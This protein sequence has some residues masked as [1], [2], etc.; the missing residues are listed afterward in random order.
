LHNSLPTWTKKA[1]LNIIEKIGSVQ[2]LGLRIEADYLRKSLKGDE[3]ARGAL[4][5]KLPQMMRPDCFG[6]FLLPKEKESEAV[7]FW[8]LL[9]S[10]K[11]YSVQGYPM[12]SLLGDLNSTDFKLLYHSRDGKKTTTAENSLKAWKKALKQSNGHHVG[13][14]RLHIILPYVTGK[15]KPI[16]SVKWN[17]V[18]IYI[19]KSNASKLFDAES[20]DLLAFATSTDRAEW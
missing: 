15:E 1:P 20:I 7:S 11:L 14:L 2:R 4:L 13:S 6:T 19:D 3:N 5:T 10:Y 8:T 17:D 12:D 16:S 18:I 9:A